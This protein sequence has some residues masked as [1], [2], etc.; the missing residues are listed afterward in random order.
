MP[1][2]GSTA[3]DFDYVLSFTDPVGPTTKDSDTDN[4]NL[5]RGSVHYDKM[6][7][8]DMALIVLETTPDSIWIDKRFDVD[9]KTKGTAEGT[10]L[11]RFSGKV[12]DC[13]EFAQEVTLFCMGL[14]ERLQDRFA[15][16][17][18]FFDSL[19]DKKLYD[20]KTGTPKYVDLDADKRPIRPLIQAE[21]FEPYRHIPID[22]SDWAQL[23]L[24]NIDAVAQ[25]FC[26]HEEFEVKA[27]WL[28]MALGGACDVPPSFDVSIV[29]NKQIAGV[30][31]PD[32]SK[33][34]LTKGF[35]SGAYTTSPVV[36]EY[37]FDSRAVLEPWRKYWIVVE[38]TSSVGACLYLAV[39]SCNSNSRSHAHGNASLH[40][41]SP[42]WTDKPDHDLYF[43]VLHKSDLDWVQLREG[44]DF[45]VD[46][47]H[48]KIEFDLDDVFDPYVYTDMLRASYFKGYPT[49]SNIFQRI[50][51]DLLSDFVTSSTISP[52]D[53]LNIKPFGFRDASAAFIVKELLK[54]GHWS[55]RLYRNTSGNVVLV[56]VDAYASSN[57]GSAPFTGTFA[58]NRTFYYGRD[59]GAGQEGFVKIASDNRVK[60]SSDKVNIVSVSNPEADLFVKVLDPADIGNYG[61]SSQKAAISKVTDSL[62]E[63]ISVVELIFQNFQPPKIKGRVT[64]DPVSFLTADALFHHCNDLIYIKDTRIAF[65]GA[66]E[67]LGITLDLSTWAFTLDVIKDRPPIILD[68]LVRSPLLHV[69][70]GEEPSFVNQ[71]AFSMPQARDD[72][73][74]DWDRSRRTIAVDDTAL[75][76]NA[77]YTYKIGIGDSDTGGSTMQNEIANRTCEGD[78]SAGKIFAIDI[79]GD[80]SDDYR[81]AIAIFDASDFGSSQSWPATIKEVGL[82]NGASLLKRWVLKSPWPGSPATEDYFHPPLVINKE[83]KLFVCWIITA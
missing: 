19:I 39:Y 49:I 75:T 83:G 43:W 60:T 46:Y 50:H 57:W 30:D 35:G 47:P 4:I 32:T 10:Y 5:V 23:D 63:I 37:E 7:N 55:F 22:D 64:L 56:C 40:D 3:G 26:P 67:V 79:D 51:D 9:L 12:T 68:N 6:G 73:R 61:R 28:K 54:I 48:K 59:A 78:E 8:P 27:V 65:D 42:A 29:Q 58:D 72:P 45:T 34:V 38:I 82:Y 53:L 71:N 66:Y 20:I 24:T 11:Y 74:G 25:A 62:D 18:T 14:G 2:I 52:T 81:L 33:V 17:V 80:A 36:R 41:T 13:M 15:N 1:S 76:Y 21:Y 70:P 69:S 16:D 77:G 44:V 31:Y